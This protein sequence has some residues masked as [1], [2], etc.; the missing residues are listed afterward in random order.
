MLLHHFELF[1]T[2]AVNKLGPGRHSKPF[3]A[4]FNRVEKV[5]KLL[6]GLPDGGR[7]A[8]CSG[9]SVVDGD[10]QL[11]VASTTLK[12][13]NSFMWLT[14]INAND[15]KA[16]LAL[17]KILHCVFLSCALL[18]VRYSSIFLRKKNPP[19]KKVH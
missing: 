15:S 17:I 14:A 16:L 19:S 11:A 8:A 6:V 7:Q 10:R 3:N 4:F 5:P 2:A 1:A 13:F 18:Y 9:L 12:H